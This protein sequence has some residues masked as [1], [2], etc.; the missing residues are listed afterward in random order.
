MLVVAFQTIAVLDRFGIGEI[1]RGELESDVVVVMPQRNRAA[2][3]KAHVERRL[4]I[5]P[6]Q[7]DRQVLQQQ[8][9]C[10]RPRRRRHADLQR[11]EDADAVESAEDDASTGQP[12]RAIDPVA[13][14]ERAVMRT[15][16]EEAA[17][18]AIEAADADGR[19]DPEVALGILD[20]RT[21]RFGGQSFLATEGFE[22]RIAV[23]SGQQV[24]DAAALGADPE[25]AARVDAQRRN[26]IATDRARI[27]PV[28]AEVLEPTRFAVVAIKPSR[29][30][31]QPQVGA[32]CFDDAAD[33]IAADAGLGIVAARFGDVMSESFAG[34]AAFIEALVQGADPKGAGM[35]FV[36]VQDRILGQAGWIIGIMA[37][38]FER[39]T[40]G[41]Q[42]VESAAHRRNPQA[43]VTRAG[44]ELNEIVGQR[45]RLRRIVRVARDE[46]LVR[47]QMDQS[48]AFEDAH[49]ERAIGLTPDGQGQFGRQ[50]ARITGDA[51]DTGE[52]F[53]PRVLYRET[54]G[55]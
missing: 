6:A 34:R 2:E 45:I 12:G 37:K 29:A 47:I 9:R 43:A 13:G 27:E 38:V 10:Q 39:C 33:G 53:G 22:L 35:I 31:S 48:T 14:A 3:P 52:Y 21:D 46:T 7:L 15:E 32:R 26:R 55:P 1:Q 36:N 40:T 24:A 5:A 25:L 17:L 30:K 44:N 11:I 28:G 49:P 42:A 18:L 51:A 4:G 19:A 41:A 8:A 20:D 54:I 23:G 50:R 16:I